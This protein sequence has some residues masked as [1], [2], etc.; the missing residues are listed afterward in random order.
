MS[1]SN[2]KLTPFVHVNDLL[3]LINIIQFRRKIRYYAEI[4]Y[5]SALD[6]R[7]YRNC[8]GQANYTLCVRTSLLDHSDVSS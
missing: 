2:G 8:P 5:R 3:I 1:L 4:E 6:S 7:F